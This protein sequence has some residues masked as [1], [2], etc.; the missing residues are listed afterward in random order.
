MLKTILEFGAFQRIAFA[1]VGIEITKLAV[2]SIGFG[3]E[4]LRPC[5]KIFEAKRG[6]IEVF[7]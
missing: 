1:H 5:R 6:Y 7:F 3:E 2:A 4:A